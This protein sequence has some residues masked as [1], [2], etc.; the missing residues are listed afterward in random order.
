M[1][2]HAEDLVILAGAAPG[3]G[4]RNPVPVIDVVRGAISEVEDYKRVDISA[5]DPSAVVGRAVGDVIHLLAELIENA[6]SFSPPHTRVQVVGQ[7]VPNGY[8]VEIED[9]GLGMTA[10]AIA[11]AN[12]RLLE[13]PDFD[14]ADSARL[15]LFVVAQLAARHGIRV[16]LR[17]VAVRRR[18]RGGA[19]PGRP[20]DRP[21]R[22]DPP[23]PRARRARGPSPA[24]GLDRRAAD[25]RRPGWP[26]RLVGR[27][28]HGAGPVDGTGDHRPVP[29]AAR[30][31]G[32]SIAAGPVEARP[33]GGPRRSRLAAS[34]PSRLTVGPAAPASPPAGRRGAATP[35]SPRRPALGCRPNA[36]PAGSPASVP[37]RRHG[38][39]AGPRS[40]R[41]PAETAGVETIG[42]RAAPPG[43]AGEPGASIAGARGRAVHRCAAPLAGPGA[44]ADERPAVR[45]HAGTAGRRGRHVGAEWGVKPTPVDWFTTR[46]RVRADARCPGRRR[47]QAPGN[48]DD[49]ASHDRSTTGSR[50]PQTGRTAGTATGST[51]RRTERD[52]VRTAADD[53][54]PDPDAAVTVVHH[55]EIVPRQAA[56]R[57]STCRRPADPPTARTGEPDHPG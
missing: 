1:R 7:V 51:R 46:H 19:D 36:D 44:L 52:P 33:S 55:G 27:S 29:S 20:H 22:A 56:G 5:V 50:R 37:R 24:A 4:W 11:E 39:L 3:R 35:R 25:R 41:L 21:V 34:R 42:R 12:R 23:S 15:G 2:R 48:R 54:L 13:P 26:D 57:T 14:P 30:S 10:E 6:T 32:T 43:A 18:D 9:R 47:S 49:P 45:H 38:P 17:A 31:N 40:R 53:G 28:L 16:Q 8:V